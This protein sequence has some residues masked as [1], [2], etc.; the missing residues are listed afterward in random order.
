MTWNPYADL[1]IPAPVDEDDPDGL[2]WD[3]SRG[4]SGRLSGVPGWVGVV[5]G[6]GNHREPREPQ[7]TAPGLHLPDAWASLPGEVVPGSDPYPGN[8]EPLGMR[9]AYVDIGALLSGEV[10]DAPAPDVLAASDG[11]GLFYSGQVNHLIGDPESG[12][13]WVALAAVTSVLASGERAGVID[14]DHNGPASTVSRLLDLG[15]ARDVLGVQSRFRYIEPGDAAELR[16]VV[17]D[18]IAWGPR[19]VVVDSVGELLPLFGASSNSPDDFTRVHA[20][21]L[22]PLAAAG[23]AVVAID[24]HAKGADS[25]A[26]GATGTAAKKR[27]VGG[28]A[29]RMTLVQ[30][31]A[32]GRGGAARLTLVKDRHGGLRAR[33]PAGDREPEVGVFH[34][35]PGADDGPWRVT[36]PD[37]GSGER[38]L[39]RDAA[40]LLALDPVPVST[41]D[42]Q[43]RMG[44]RRER[45]VAAMREAGL[46][47]GS[48]TQGPEPGTTLDAVDP[49]VTALPDES[50]SAWFP[51]P[52]TTLCA[53]CG[54]P[55]L[56]LGDGA[57]THPGCAS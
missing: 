29:L 45:V 17:A 34:L 32:P 16:A 1:L 28:T 52:G 56:V 53:V 35:H 30:A 12:K 55:M 49:Q 33:R 5:P 3:G 47:P 40:M 22:K 10:V 36:A 38:S 39:S 21:T 15:A 48:H 44:W 8:R 31:F 23:A 7:V 27:A 51:A 19:V 18:M 37:Q 24:H 41:R 50:G 46:V 20:V 9:P 25:R 11:V 14:L 26:Q 13:T 54:T 4:G 42:A 6:S 2:L 43:R 57:T